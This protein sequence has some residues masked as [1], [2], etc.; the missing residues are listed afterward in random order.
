MLNIFIGIDKRQPVAYHV[1]VSSIQRRASQPV[2]FTPLLIDQLPISRR[3]LT[4][5]TFARFLVPY[6]CGYKGKGVFLD[7]DMLVTGDISELFEYSDDTAVSVVPFQGELQYERPSVMVFNNERCQELTPE[8][9]DDLTNEPFNLDWADSV[10]EL[11]PTWN[12]LVG[13]DLPTETPP[14]LIHYTQGV[15]G[16]KECRRCDYADLWT[17][18]LELVKHHVSW[19]EIMGQSKHAK[20]VLRKLNFA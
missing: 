5:F 7:S 12:F 10:G 9:I 19:L 16:Y 4:D 6:L 18:E 20:Y 2:A 13:Y 14:K 17:H 15:P 3:G 1:L 11:D 8:Y